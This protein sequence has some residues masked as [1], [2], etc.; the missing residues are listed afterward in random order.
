MKISA[1]TLIKKNF[2][3]VLDLNLP[4]LKKGQ[5]LVKIKYSSIC[6]T[7]IQEIMGLRGKD[8]YLPHC[9]GHE[10]TGLV[11]E[12]GPG[13]KKVKKND[14]VCLTWLQSDGKKASGVKYL[15]KK[16][17]YKWRSSKYFFKLCNCKRK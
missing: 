16:K 4:K 17:N 7:Q 9:L 12:V 13:V 5:V 2:I 6:H 15:H 8:R 11:K 1:A 10:A 3:K 14:K